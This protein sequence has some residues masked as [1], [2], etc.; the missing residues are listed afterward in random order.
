MLLSTHLLLPSWCHQGLSE[1]FWGLIKSCQPRCRGTIA[2]VHG[3][4]VGAQEKRSVN[5]LERCDS[6]AAN[7]A[8]KQNIISQMSWI[9]PLPWLLPWEVL[10]T[11]YYQVGR[12]E[13]CPWHNKLQMIC[14][15][16]L[17][18]KR[19]NR[20]MYIISVKWTRIAGL[21]HPLLCILPREVL[22]F[23]SL[24]CLYKQW[25]SNEWKL[26]RWM[27]LVR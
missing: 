24:V 13:T 11:W 27:E 2:D 3:P 7:I 19:C 4:W 14:K 20:W 10:T 16:I 21:K 17:S 22:T 18:L 8:N 9:H 1:A 15:I 26:N 6:S 23:T 12:C 25:I 5:K